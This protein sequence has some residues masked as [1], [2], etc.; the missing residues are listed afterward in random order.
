MNYE[1]AKSEIEYI[2]NVLTWA[3]E[4]A[5]ADSDA[6]LNISLAK[7]RLW[8]ILEAITEWGNEDEDNEADDDTNWH[9]AR[10]H[11]VNYHKTRVGYI[12]LVYNKD[13]GFFAVATY[14]GKRQFWFKN[15][16]KPIEGITHIAL[17][18]KK[19]TAQ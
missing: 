2:Q 3:Y 4:Y 19:N 15:G 5:D 7:S 11:R 12:Y 17:L 14:K 9:E 18:P 8:G 10:W 6:R 1:Q 13:N 16:T